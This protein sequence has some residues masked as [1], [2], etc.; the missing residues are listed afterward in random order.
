MNLCRITRYF[1]VPESLYIK[2]TYLSFALD[3]EKSLKNSQTGDAVFPC[4]KS[5]LTYSKRAN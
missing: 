3:L 4:I 2:M 5:L 1:E